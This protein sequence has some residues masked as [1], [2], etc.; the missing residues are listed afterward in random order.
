MNRDGTIKS[1]GQAMSLAFTLNMWNTEGMQPFHLGA[2]L[3]CC[4]MRKQS[5]S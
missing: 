2:L 5:T 4:N 1:A 3:T